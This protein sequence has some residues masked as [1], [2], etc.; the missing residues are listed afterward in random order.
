[1]RPNDSPPFGGLLLLSSTLDEFSDQP[2]DAHLLIGDG[3]DLIGGG[4][5]RLDERVE[6]FV[7]QD[8]GIES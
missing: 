7:P 8:V 2:V 6:V 3:G 5:R 4:D 1:M